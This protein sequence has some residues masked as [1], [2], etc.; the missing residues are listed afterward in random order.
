MLQEALSD[1]LLDQP[2]VLPAI[3][4]LSVGFG[5][6]TWF[7]ARHVGLARIPAV[8]AS[9]GLAVALSV[10]LVRFG[11]Q[12]NSHP[13][14]LHVGECRANSLSV[15]GIQPL[16][17]IAMLMPFAF[18]ATIAARKATPVLLASASVSAAIELAQAYTGLGFCEAQD[19][20]NNTAGAAVA[21]LSARLLIALR[22]LHRTTTAVG[23]HALPTARQL[24]R[25]RTAG[26]APIPR[27]RARYNADGLPSLRGQTERPMLAGQR[28]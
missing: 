21:A 16:L 3:F 27:Q 20:L 22:A 13:S 8:L 28:H 2:S 17:N 6:V 18:L 24:R 1:A 23:K 11:S 15:Q 4:L 19:F 7:S 14:V 9:S 5:A 12:M 25:R 26:A 10:T